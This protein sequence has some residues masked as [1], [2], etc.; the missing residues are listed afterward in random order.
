MHSGG[1]APALRWLVEEG[2]VLHYAGRRACGNT[3]PFCDRSRFGLT[4][5]GVAL[6]RLSSGRPLTASAPILRPH[7][8]ADS[9]QLTIVGRVVKH[10]RADAEN[11]RLILTAFEEED[12]ATS[13]D[14]PLP[15]DREIDPPK[16]LRNAVQRLNASQH[17]SLICFLAIRGAT[18]VR[19]ELTT[20]ASTLLAQSESN[21]EG[22]PRRTSP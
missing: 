10:V 2:L 14:D 5:K 6:A 19:W 12:W 7:W 17:P 20:R 9:G 16:R 21:G 15:G 8:D 13:V 1:S 4:P 3:A 11:L 18:G 22:S